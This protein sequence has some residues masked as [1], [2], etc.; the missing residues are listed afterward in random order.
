MKHVEASSPETAAKKFAADYGEGEAGV[1]GVKAED[2]WHRFPV[3][4]ADPDEPVQ[5]LPAF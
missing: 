5:W 4:A 2:R 1:Y 3:P